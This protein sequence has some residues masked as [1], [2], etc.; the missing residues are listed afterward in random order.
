MD[1]K[2]YSVEDFVLDERFR[3][4]VID[5]DRDS[6]IFWTQWLDKH[7]QKAE[8]VAHAIELLRQLPVQQNSLSEQQISSIIEAIEKSIDRWEESG[9]K[10]IKQEKTVPISVHAMTQ[11]KL[12]NTK[13]KRPRSKSFFVKIA[14]SMVLVLSMLYVAYDEV[15]HEKQE[16]EVV[17]E[18]VVKENPK[19]QKMTVFLA[20]G[21]K[22]MLNAGSK[23]SFTKPFHPDYRRVTLEG[24]AFFEV[25]KDSL[26]PFQVVSDVITTIALG[27]SFNIAAYPKDKH[28]Q[29]SLASGKVQVDYQKAMEN[30]EPEVYYLIPGEQLDYDKEQHILAKEPFDVD[31]VLAW[32]N[33]IIYLENADQANVIKTLERWYGVNIKIEGKSATAW[34]VTA[35]FNNQSLKSVLISLSY[36]MGFEFEIKEDLVLIKYSTNS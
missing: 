22:V 23:L 36:T 7:P 6:H 29:V 16:P 21:S 5:P 15:H 26:R 9:R 13:S 17:Y 33:G 19:G 31:K 18:E 25:A 34:S 11:R 27:T 4:W 20:D 24:E 28:I 10:L 1:Y 14:A 12:K 3:K 35:K 32:K 2:Q 30:Q 8:T